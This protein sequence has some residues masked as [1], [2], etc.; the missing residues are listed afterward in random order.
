MRVGRTV[1]TT[2]ALRCFHPVKMIRY[3]SQSQTWTAIQG[4]TEACERHQQ[5]G[6]QSWLHREPQQP[7]AGWPASGG[8]TIGRHQQ[9]RKHQGLL[10]GSPEKVWQLERWLPAFLVVLGL[11][12]LRER[13]WNR[14]GGGAKKKNHPSLILFLREDTFR[15]ESPALFSRVSCACSFNLQP[16][17]G[18]PTW[19]SRKALLQTLEVVITTSDRADGALVLL[20]SVIQGAFNC[21]TIRVRILI[22]KTIVFLELKYNGCMKRGFESNAKSPSVGTPVYF[23]CCYFVI[24]LSQLFIFLIRLHVSAV[25]TSLPCR[26]DE[27]DDIYNFVEGR[28]QDET[29]G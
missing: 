8:Q 4:R 19:T 22:G 12:K 20:N 13:H 18:L 26:E 29:G 14:P 27:F 23:W 6:K 3:L 15:N 21:S 28:L 2:L 11:A 5:I 1:K 9:R 24:H 16:S 25:P 17:P 10:A 7:M